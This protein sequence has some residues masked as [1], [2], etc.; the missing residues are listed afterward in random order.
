MSVPA[1]GAAVLDILIQK[2]EA[3]EGEGW[4]L[5]SLLGWFGGVAC[6][7]SQSDVRSKVCFGE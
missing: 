2:V 3:P 7:I 6:P 4:S 5:G 1:F